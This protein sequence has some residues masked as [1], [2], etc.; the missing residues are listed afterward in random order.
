MPC[1]KCLAAGSTAQLLCVCKSK[2]CQAGTKRDLMPNQHAHGERHSS[3]VTVI[4][5]AVL[6]LFSYVSNLRRIKLIFASFRKC[7]QMSE[8]AQEHEKLHLCRSR[9]RP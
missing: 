9:W 4:Q 3:T 8:S 7:E 2:A 6:N 5:A 1:M